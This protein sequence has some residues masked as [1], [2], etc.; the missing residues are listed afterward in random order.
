MNN[1]SL[2][3]LSNIIGIISIILLVYWVFIF[4]A[5]TVFGLKVFRENITETFY[6]SVLGILALMFG[7]LIL[8]VMCNLTRIA[9]KH[10]QDDLQISKRKGAKLGLIF[11]LSFPI[12][13]TFLFAGNYL[14]SVKKEKMLISSAKSIIE[15]NQ[16]KS[17]KLLNYRF[18]RDWI[19]ET[20][21]IIDILAKTDKHFP[22]VSVI[23]ADSID[24]S[25]AFLGFG[26]YYQSE[27]DTIPPKKRN[28]IVKTSK[29]ERDYLN[30]V[31]SEGL[32]DVKFSAE[33][34][35][36]ELFYPYIKDGK[37]IVL[38]FSDYQRYGKFGS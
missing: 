12:I 38:Y 34:G 13:L 19:N 2:V 6:V 36:Y 26:S 4:I 15:D 24:Q 25:K 20:S 9:E 1:K 3:R 37:K 35:Q 17:N 8:N 22:H 29:E 23:T 11:A 32:K 16:D 30:K 33:K 21:E 7:S 5:T 27:H 18:E 10:N 14:T 28:F 31:F